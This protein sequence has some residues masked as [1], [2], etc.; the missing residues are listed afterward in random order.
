MGFEEVDLGTGGKRRSFSFSTPRPSTHP[1]LAHFSG[2][3]D[4]LLVCLNSDLHKPKSIGGPFG[5]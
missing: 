4:G 1:F 3:I 5:V 2:R